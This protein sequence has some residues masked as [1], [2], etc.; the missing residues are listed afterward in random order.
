MVKK[1]IR[2]L[3]KFLMIAGILLLCLIYSRKECP[4][5]KPLKQEIVPE[6]LTIN[7]LQPL[8]WDISDIKIAKKNKLKQPE[9]KKETNTIKPIW[10]YISFSQCAPDP[11]APDYLQRRFQKSNDKNVGGLPNLDCGFIRTQIPFSF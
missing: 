9:I 10:E 4:E 11:R 3:L 6:N 1:S 5:N 2:F 7:Y 8:T